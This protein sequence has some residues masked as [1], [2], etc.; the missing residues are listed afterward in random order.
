VRGCAT[1]RWS[2]VQWCVRACGC[3]GW[4]PRHTQQHDQRGVQT[5]KRLWAESRWTSAVTRGY[6]EWR[7][8]YIFARNSCWLN[9]PTA[10]GVFPLP[11]EAC[12][13]NDTRR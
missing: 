6:C 5:S 13:M 2:H 4:Q 7:R 9:E 10:R 11:L 8:A 3:G 1:S 12:H